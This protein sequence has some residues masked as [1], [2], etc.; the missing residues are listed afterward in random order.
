MLSCTLAP[1]MRARLSATPAAA[2]ATTIR[3]LPLG[4]LSALAAAPQNKKAAANMRATANARP[5]TD[6]SLFAFLPLPGGNSALGLKA[7][8][9]TIPDRSMRRRYTRHSREFEPRPE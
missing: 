5:R 9:R 3:I 1:T 2:V 4:K 6:A 8:Q 7:G